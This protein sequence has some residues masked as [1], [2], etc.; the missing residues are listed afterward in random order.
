MEIKH[1]NDKSKFPNARDEC[2]EKRQLQFDRFTNKLEQMLAGG[3][4][5]RL[6]ASLQVRSAQLA[7]MESRRTSKDKA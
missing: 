2:M 4:R 5:A 7:H 3:N 6:P 1:Y